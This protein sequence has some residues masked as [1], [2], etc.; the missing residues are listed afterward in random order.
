LA[1]SPRTLLTMRWRTENCTLVWAGSRFQVTASANEGRARATTISRL[2]MR[3]L[4]CARASSGKWIDA[5]RRGEHRGDGPGEPL[6]ERRA[7]IGGIAARPAVA[8][9]LAVP[10]GQRPRATRGDSA[11]G[12]RRSLGRA[13]RSRTEALRAGR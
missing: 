6:R 11:P 1:N 12:A 9:G 2:R 7:R 8:P 5:P 4:L 3:P 10:H 13:P